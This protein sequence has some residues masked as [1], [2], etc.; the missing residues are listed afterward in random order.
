[1]HF[2]NFGCALFYLW[3]LVPVFF[4]CFILISPSL[5]EAA[6]TAVVTGTTVNVRSGPS[7]DYAAF[8]QVNQGDRLPVLDKFYNWYYVNLPGGV[9]GWISGQLVRIEQPEPPE[10]SSGNVLTIMINTDGVNIRSGPGTSYEIVARAS[11]GQHYPVMETSGDWYKVWLGTNT[12][13]VANWLVA[14]KTGVSPTSPQTVPPAASTPPAVQT[15]GKTAVVNGSQVNVRKGPGTANALVGQVSRGDEL[16][17]LGQD[18]DWYQVK[19]AGGSNGWVAGWLVSLQ[20]AAPAEQV[21]DH[22]ENPVDNHAPQTG[23]IDISRGGEDREPD[24]Q[25]G[26]AL[27]LQIK[28]TG[29]QTSAVV[30]ADVPFEYDA[31]ALSGPDRLVL[32]LKGI[33]KG[34]L[35][36]KTDVNSKTVKQIRVGHYQR[37]PDITRLVFDLSGGAQYV[38]T[39]SRDKKS[40]NV[41]TYIPT[42]S[43]SYAGTTIAIDA[44]HGNPDPGA[45]GRNGLV[46]NDI[47]FDIAKRTKKLLEAKG[48]RVI[49]TRT[50]DSEIG[51]EER[52]NRANKAGADLFVSIH[53]NAHTDPSIG[54]TMTYICNGNGTAAEASRNQESN[55]LARYVQAELVKK[56]GL[57]D[58][59]VR[60]ANFVVLRKAKMPAVL[61]E[62]AFISNANEEKLMRTDSFRNKSAEAI[63]NGIGYYISGK[64]TR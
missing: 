6:E 58:G 47:T 1:M 43:G 22:V 5:T 36:S 37:E 62:L 13:W 25:S 28:E 3:V 30:V 26:K 10:L 45:I 51:L 18:G 16:P 60:S 20:D 41:E 56:L 54:G 63:V 31:F 19:L 46:E 50:G 29:G 32:D 48:A 42:I 9:N 17:V 35:P 49:M 21:Q 40:I 23:S 39:H 53:V 27:T 55:R 59:G 24:G 8:T 14:R 57:R 15:S 34:E 52:A 2:R 61:T 11:Y 33:A 4:F 64:K 38:T 12:G 7:L 44:G